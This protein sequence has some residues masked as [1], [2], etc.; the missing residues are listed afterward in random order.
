MRLSDR[1]APA[2]IAAGTRLGESE[3]MAMLRLEE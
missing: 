3:A 1:L 2:V